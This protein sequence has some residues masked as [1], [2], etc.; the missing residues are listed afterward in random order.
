MGTAKQ[1]AEEPPHVIARAETP[2]DA[3]LQSFDDAGVFDLLI[4][5]IQAD[6]PFERQHPA[7]AGRRAGQSPS[8]AIPH[9]GIKV[10]RVYPDAVYRG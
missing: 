1:Q 6:H 2:H 8:P 10:R 9:V 4:A 5:D 7:I 3:H